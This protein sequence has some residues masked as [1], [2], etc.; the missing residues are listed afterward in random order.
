M[1][2]DRGHLVSAAAAAAPAAAAA[3]AT[4]C[5]ESLLPPTQAGGKAHGVPRR[6]P[7]LH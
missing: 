7:G 6:A 1:G 5:S 4:P 2:I 3:A